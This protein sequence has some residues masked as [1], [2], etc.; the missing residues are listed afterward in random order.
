MLCKPRAA[1][2]AF[3]K[4]KCWIISFSY[5]IDLPMRWH[6]QTLLTMR[7]KD[8]LF[9]GI[10][11]HDNFIHLYSW[12]WMGRGYRDGITF[13][14]AATGAIK[15]CIGRGY[16]AKSD[17]DALYF[18]KEW[19]YDETRWD[20]PIIR[21]SFSLRYVSDFQRMDN[22]HIRF[23]NSRRIIVYG[24]FIHQ[25][26]LVLLIGLKLPSNF[27]KCLYYISIKIYC[28]LISCYSY[29]HIPL[30]QSLTVTTNAAE[31]TRIE[32]YLRYHK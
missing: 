23:L 4:W 22:W 2:T 1:V 19:C 25:F 28:F 15:D 9:A 18:L 10:A 13:L 29:K 24:C 3:L 32:L 7:Y 31:D 14:L 21:Y 17:T 6:Q 5:F 26:N 8:H 27:N 12:N 16:W 11:V 30:R 20:N